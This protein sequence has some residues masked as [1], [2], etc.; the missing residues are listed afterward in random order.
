MVAFYILTEGQ[1][2]FG[3]GEQVRI[4]LLAANPV[5]LKMLDG[6]LFAKDLISW[7][8]SHDAKDRPSAEEALQHPYLKSKEQ[9]FKLL[10]G[11]GNYVKRKD[12]NSDV[13]EKLNENETDWKTRVDSDVL[14][15]LSYDKE[16][17]RKYE[18][19]SWADCL[20]LIR[21]IKEHWEDY[22]RTEPEA[23]KVGDPQE[24]FLRLFPD[25]VLGVY[26]IARSCDDLKELLGLKEY[27]E[28]Q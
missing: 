4:N 21:N 11:M 23:I 5:N 12:A 8:L 1:H 16:K 18:Y 3:E 13:L 26:K 25:L 28:G 15:Y 7:M 22:E 19:T 9:Q 14:E 2:P 24:Y 10:W 6:H 27:F 17:K 20:R